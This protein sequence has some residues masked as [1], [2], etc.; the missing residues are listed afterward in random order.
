MKP[1]ERTA[2]YWLCKGFSNKRIALAMTIS[3]QSAKNLL[4]S[5]Y[6]KLGVHGRAAAILVASERY[7]L[8]ETTAQVK[9]PKA[10]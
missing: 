6:D 3:E 2:L 1:R 5:V 10:Q 9:P 4:R 8:F 7:S